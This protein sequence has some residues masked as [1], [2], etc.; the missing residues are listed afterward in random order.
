MSFLTLEGVG[1]TYHSGS[2]DVKALEDVS[3]SLEDGEFVVVLGSSGAG[4]TTLLNLLGGMDDA[5][6]GKIVL[7]GREV[8]GLDKRG[9]AATAAKTSAS[10]SSF[11]T[12][13]PT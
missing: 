1:K 3:F 6:E 9:S 13:C 2:V 12:S 8:T 7:G 5:T 11:T 4:K 10:S